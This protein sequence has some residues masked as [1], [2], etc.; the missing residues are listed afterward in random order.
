MTE[1]ES[2]RRLELVDE[3][4]A[5]IEGILNHEHKDRPQK[6]VDLL[7]LVMRQRRDMQDHVLS[8]LNLPPLE[9]D[10]FEAFRGEEGE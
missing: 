3:I 7:S 6:V 5:E 8:D 9:P 1:F 10:E 4:R 2:R